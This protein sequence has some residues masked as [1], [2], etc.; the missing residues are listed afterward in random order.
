MASKGLRAIQFQVPQ[1]VEEGYIPT[2]NT[3]TL[4]G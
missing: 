2:L 3:E 4:I 1:N